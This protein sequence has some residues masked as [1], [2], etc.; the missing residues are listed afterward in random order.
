MPRIVIFDLDGTLAKSKSPL[1][2]DMGVLLAQL[3]RKVP[4]AI[5]SGGA[6]KQFQTQLLSGMPPQADFRQMYLMPTSAA[7][8][9]AWNGSACGRGHLRAPEPRGP[10]PA[11]P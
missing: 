6:F 3:A 5:M 2:P 7:Q 10:R 11:K 9:Y 1:T 8:C 4:V